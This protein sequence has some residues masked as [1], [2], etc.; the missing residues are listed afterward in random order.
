M[1]CNEFIRNN[2]GING[3]DDLPRDFLVS[4]YDNISK[5]EIKISSEAGGSADASPMLWSELNQQ[6]RAPRGKML[7]IPS[8]GELASEHIGV[9]LVGAVHRSPHVKWRLPMLRAHCLLSSVL[10]LYTGF[11]V[12]FA[13]S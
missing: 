1:T 3:G 9:S 7:E 8:I 13:A 4:L 11:K 12:L 10:H 2:R 5:N 6:S